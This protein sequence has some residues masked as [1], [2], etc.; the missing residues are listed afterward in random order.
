[1]GIGLP[2]AI[3][4]KLLYPERRVVTVTGD[5]GFLMNSQELGTAV[6][7]NVPVVI[8]VW[9]DNGYG[10]IRWK[11]E[12]RFHRAFGV[13]FNNPDLVAYAE[14]FGA[15]GFRVEGPTEL[16]AVMKAALACGKPAVID[17][18]VDYSENRRLSE[19]LHSLS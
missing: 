18:P 12:V 15:A 3:V 1:M 6:R 9:R 4:A 5:G 13:E 7:L 10:V 16:S 17:C 14:S 19:R 8:L 11:Q 2:G